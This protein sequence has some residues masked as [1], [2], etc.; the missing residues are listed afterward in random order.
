VTPETRAAIGRRLLDEGREAFTLQA[1][2]LLE[3]DNPELL[4]TAHNFAAEH[5]NYHE[6]MLGFALVYQ[7][8]DLQKAADRT[9]MH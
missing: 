4:Q 8:L 9:S 5:E 7:C 1:I 6:A 2:E 3:C